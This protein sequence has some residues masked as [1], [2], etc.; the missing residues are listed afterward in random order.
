MPKKTRRYYMAECE[1][2][3]VEDGYKQKE[4]A[5]KRELHAPQ[6]PNSVTRLTSSVTLVW[7]PEEKA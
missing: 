6:C 2:G 5:R 1:C 4:V 7:N 3:W